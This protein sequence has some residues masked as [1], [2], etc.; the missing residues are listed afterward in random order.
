MSMAK[1]TS[2]KRVSRSATTGRFI[3]NPAKAGS[4]E[5][6]QVDRAVKKVTSHRN[7]TMT[8]RSVH[9]SKTRA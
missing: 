1:N 6:R 7:G 9:S 8:S 3:K 5:Y 2:G 4:V